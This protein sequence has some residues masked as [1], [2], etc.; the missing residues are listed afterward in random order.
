[1]SGGPRGVLQLSVAVGDYDRTRPLLDGTVAIDGVEPVFLRLSPEEMFFR[2]F[3]HEAFDV[4]E[5][6]LSSFALRTARGDNPYLGVPVFLSRAF[7]HTSIVVRTDR[8]IRQPADL[9]GRRIGIPEYQ[10]TACVWARGLLEDD[11]GVRPSD[12]QWVRGGMEQP[13][14]I[15]KAAVALPSDVRL[16]DAPGD[17]TLSAMLEAGELEGIIG[18]RLPSCFGRPGVPVGWLFED[19]AAAAA[20]YYRR[21][22]IFPVM[23]L[24]GVRRALVERH[25]WLPGTLAKAF[26]QAKGAALAHLAD[27]SAPKVT[28]PFVEEQLQAARGLMG[29][30]FWAYGVESNRAVLDTFLRHHHRQGLSPRRVAV[31][32]P[33]HP[34]TVE[35][36][37]I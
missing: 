25:P 13:G 37:R 26:E 29:P 16:T 36:H 28:L 11:F 30:D 1:M 4:C 24:L 22:G 33:F 7:R 27:T 31:E 18:P 20:E 5:L 12:I 21:T 6:S 34:S 23:H 32:E 9:K 10:L 8:D 17:R 35:V 19:P 2:A 3:R 15:E 14:R